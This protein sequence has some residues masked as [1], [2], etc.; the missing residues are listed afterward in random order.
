MHVLL[1]GGCDASLM[2]VVEGEGPTADSRR[3]SRALAAQELV[4]ASSNA[5]PSR[6]KEHAAACQSVAL[7]GVRQVRSSNRLR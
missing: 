5:Q 2:G 4:E 7:V 1:S 6:A 3:G